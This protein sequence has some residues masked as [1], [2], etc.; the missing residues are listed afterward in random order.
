MKYY[1]RNIV[2]SIILACL[3]V[4]IFA[5]MTLV[6]NKSIAFLNIGVIAEVIVAWIAYW[7]FQHM[8]KLIEQENLDYLYLNRHSCITQSRFIHLVLLAIY[9]IYASNSNRPILWILVG[10]SSLITLFVWILPYLR[11]GSS[12]YNV[13]L[14]EN[15]AIL[16]ISI[17]GINVI[18]EIFSSGQ[19]ITANDKYF[20]LFAVFFTALFIFVWYIANGTYYL[21]D[22]FQNNRQ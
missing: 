14:L 22:N 21:N 16:L 10:I 1:K 4:I 6:P 8:A 13:I 11:I 12:F 3:Q 19:P 15:L 5:T 2:V 20:G 9:S 18:T 7:Y 17:V